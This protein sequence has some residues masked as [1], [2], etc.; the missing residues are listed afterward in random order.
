MG[1]EV[2]SLWHPTSFLLLLFQ[3]CGGNASELSVRRNL[4]GENVH[5]YIISLI[6]L[7]EEGFY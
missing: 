7:L 5:I 4:D 1:L 2:K 6:F 3:L